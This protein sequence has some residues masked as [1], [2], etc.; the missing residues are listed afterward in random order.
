MIQEGNNKTMICCNCR[1]DEGVY[2]LTV[3]TKFIIVLLAL[4]ITIK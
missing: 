1:L 2:K 4:L 3:A